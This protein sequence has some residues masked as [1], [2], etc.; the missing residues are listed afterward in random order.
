[1]IMG[2]IILK[3]KHLFKRFYAT[4][5]HD[6]IEKE[7]YLWQIFRRFDAIIGI[8]IGMAVAIIMN[9]W[10]LPILYFQLPAFS[11]KGAF[12]LLF[13]KAVMGCVITVLLGAFIVSPQYVT[14]KFGK[15]GFKKKEELH[16]G[17]LLISSILAKFFF[18]AMITQPFYSVYTC[19]KHGHF[20]LAGAGLVSS[21][22]VMPIVLIIM[23]SNAR[24]YAIWRMKWAYQHYDSLLSR[25]SR[26]HTSD[27]DF[28]TDRQNL[29]YSVSYKKVLSI[30]F[31]C[32]PT[33]Y[34]SLILAHAVEKSQI[35]KPKTE[36]SAKVDSRADVS[37]EKEQQRAI[38]DIVSDTNKQDRDEAIE[39]LETD[40]VVLETT[41]AEDGDERVV[42]PIT[43]KMKGRIGPYEVAG[44][45]IFNEDDSFT[46]TYG[47]N[48]NTTMLT[49]KGVVHDDLSIEIE[50]FTRSGK[51]CGFYKGRESSY[52]NSMSGTFTNSKGEIFNFEWEFK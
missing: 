44:M 19:L 43:R 25:Y 13:D 12:N 37:I 22:I 28:N 47:Y 46:G 10:L 36:V 18:V 35:A 5:T 17:H 29:K 32:M 42:F 41:D 33:I 9:C 21:L 34:S 2:V 14:D 16:A 26:F 1:M 45:F 48:G 15:R 3:L 23:E 20:L 8:V 24:D 30:I 39:A 40:T 27:M 6:D 11:S 50:E 7:M 49:I 38:N 4:F 31:L 52:G 51:K